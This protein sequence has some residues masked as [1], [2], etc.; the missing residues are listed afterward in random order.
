MMNSS[1]TKKDPLQKYFSRHVNRN[2]NAVKA[3]EI[4]WRG[5]GEQHI[6]RDVFL[7]QTRNLSHLGRKGLGLKTQ[8]E[9]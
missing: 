1:K 4:G 3:S 6:M 5:E 9:A 2:E 8:M 7:R